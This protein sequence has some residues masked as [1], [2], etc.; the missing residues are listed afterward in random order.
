[1]TSHLSDELELAEYHLHCERLWL[2][3]HSLGAAGRLG[4]QTQITPI[5]YVDLDFVQCTA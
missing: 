1:M 2:E 3:H 5:G 4:N